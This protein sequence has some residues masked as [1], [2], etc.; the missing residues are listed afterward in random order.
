MN[1]PEINLKGHNVSG[2]Q[3]ISKVIDAQA[4]LKETREENATLRKDRD[5]LLAEYIALRDK[6]K[7]V[8]SPMLKR[9]FAGKER[10]RVSAGDMHGMMMDKPAVEAFLSDVRILDPDEVILGGDMLECGGWLAKHMALGYVAQTDYSYQEDVSACNWFLDQLQQAAPHAL[11]LMLEGNHE[12]LHPEHEVL[13]KDGWKPIKDVTTN[14][15]VASLTNARKVVFD[16]PTKIHNYDY[17]GDLLTCNTCSMSFKVTPNHRLLCRH[18]Y[19]GELDYRL[20]EDVYSA[21]PHA[22][23]EIPTHGTV[24]ANEYPISDNE[25][26][27]LGWILTDGHIS[28]RVG[29]SQ[30]KEEGIEVIRNLLNDLNIKYTE[31]HRTR[32]IA[33]ICGVKLLH[34]R[35]QVSFDILGEDRRRV[36]KLLGIDNWHY[37]ERYK[38]EIPAYAATLSDRQFDILLE[39]VI[40]GDGTSV[41]AAHCI[42]GTLEF[43]SRLQEQCVIHGWRATISSRARGGE[44]AYW[45]LNLTRREDYRLC[46]ESII[47]QEYN[48]KVYCLTMPQGNFC[49]RHNGRAHF[50]GNSRVERWCV[51]QTMSHNRDAEFLRKAFAPQFMLRLEER[52]IQY[53]RRSEVYVPGLPPGWIKRGKMF[54]CH[55]LAG[56]KNAASAAVARTGGNVTFFHTHQVSSGTLVLPAIGII[57]AFC[58]GCLCQRQPLWKH[59]EPSNWSTGYAIDIIAAD[60]SFQHIDVPI[61]DG[62]S[63]ASAM[64][65]RFK[66]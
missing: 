29:I 18:S 65:T 13:C 46:A 12:C 52:K 36:A 7:V 38:K 30:S 21:G 59:S 4:K 10:V 64:I 26:R 20:A 55:E 45:C 22:S 37:A 47:K 17:H 53:V 31:Q 8:S 63:L 39:A 60:E 48:G 6:R 62:R 54:F 35:E 33:E 15:L 3:I 34:V 51:D 5:D 66:S 42:Y 28:A 14:D 57:K 49:T 58:P 19:T 56:G 41:G 9:T 16:K 23:V 1:T 27:L 40:A 50:T 43:L 32:N 44:H 25:L 24:E 61:W 11:I 2:D